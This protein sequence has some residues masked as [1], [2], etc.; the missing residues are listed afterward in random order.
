[1]NGEKAVIRDRPVVV[2]AELSTYAKTV[3]RVLDGLGAGEV[4]AG[5]QSIVLKPNLIQANPPPVTTDVRCVEAVVAFCKDVSHARL[6]VADGAGGCETTECFA[7]LGYERL[8][9]EY[10]VELVDLNH[11]ETVT[12]ADESNIFLKEFHIPEVLLESYL[13]SVP[14][15][16]AHSMAGVTLGIKNML[17]VAPER[18]YGSGGHYK[19]WGLHEQ[20]DRA[21]IEINKFRKPDL[22]LIDAAI[23][24]ATAHLWGPKCDPPVGK[25]VASFDPV[26]ADKVGCDLLGKDWKNVRHL[27]LADGL[28][29]CAEGCVRQIEL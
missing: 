13:I 21:I 23:G 17:G 8:A 26:A 2:V 27:H 25:I 6:I 20:L 5:Q 10:G 24:M 28:L 7:K 12:L 9:K 29:G 18:Y 1:M 19:K 11:A 14:V 4:L 3:P 16:K 22:T 15:L